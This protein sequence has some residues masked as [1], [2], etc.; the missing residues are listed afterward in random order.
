MILAGNLGESVCRD[1]LIL[2]GKLGESAGHDGMTLA[3]VLKM[4]PSFVEM[5]FSEN[6]EA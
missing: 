2:A 4:S 5:V 1:G 6:L 3:G